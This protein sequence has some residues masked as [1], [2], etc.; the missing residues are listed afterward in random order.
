MAHGRYDVAAGLTRFGRDLGAGPADRHV[1]QIDDDFPRY[2]R[3][4]QATRRRRPGD[5]YL[6]SPNLGD[7]VLAAVTGFI[8]RRL[9]EEH[10]ERFTLEPGRLACALTGDVVRLDNPSTPSGPFLDALDAL[11]MQVQEDLAIVR[12]DAD[13]DADRE[14]LAAVHLC[15][16][17]GWSAS[18]KVGRSFAD[19][20]APVAGM[21]ALRRQGPALVRTMVNAADGL[22]RFAWGITFAP[23]LDRHPDR[24]AA[25]FDPARPAA[26]LRVERQT[27]WGFARLGAALFTI[28][29][30]VTDVATLRR[31]PARALPLA[32]ALRSMTDASAAYKGLADSRDALAEWIE[33]GP[34]WA[35][36]AETGRRGDTER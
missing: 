1:F 30:Y 24:P 15:F 12:L 20:H 29:T 25:P 3:E 2:R 18:E 36:D 27:T 35:E 34:R 17:N 6:R 22:V 11:A 33:A 31:D 9:A 14:W 7:G 4:K 13:R 10:P 19:V 32:A 21:D 5:F 16:P 8:A 26:F 28:R 23:D